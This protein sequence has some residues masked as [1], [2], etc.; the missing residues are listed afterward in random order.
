MQHVDCDV[1]DA[2]G[3]SVGRFVKREPERS[4]RT[5]DDL[6]AKRRELAATGDE[7]GVDVGFDRA[8]ERQPVSRR[9]RGYASMS[10]RGSMTAAVCVRSQAIRNEL[11]A[12]P[13]SESLS[14]MR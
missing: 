3:L 7:I 5:G 1:P 4:P 6:R 13:S 14:N 9:Y 10:R 12:R 2:Q 8:S 11:C